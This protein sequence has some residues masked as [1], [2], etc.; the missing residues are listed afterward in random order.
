LATI[1][2]N[3][4][5]EIFD[6]KS[7]HG[8]VARID[9]LLVMLMRIL[10]EHVTFQTTLKILKKRANASEK[11]LQLLVMLTKVECKDTPSKEGKHLKTSTGSD[12][13]DIPPSKDKINAPKNGQVLSGEEQG[14]DERATA[15]LTQLIQKPEHTE[16]LATPQ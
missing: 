10:D 6:V 12:V 16:R 11:R 13:H 7:C 4:F 14:L 1:I 9:S 5:A 3:K 15:L 8:L 2:F